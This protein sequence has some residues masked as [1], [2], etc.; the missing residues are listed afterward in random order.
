MTGVSTE[1]QD[2]VLDEIQD[3]VTILTLNN[4]AR[5]N[6]VSSQLLTVLKAKLDAVAVNKEVRVVIIRAEG[7]V[8]S[9]GHDRNHIGA[10]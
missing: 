2:L 5:R 9:S 10:I 8:Y 3:G 4:P 7:P 6:A 1:A